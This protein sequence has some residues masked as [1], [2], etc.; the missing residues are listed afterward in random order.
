MSLR[1][2]TSSYFG[3]GSL[4]NYRWIISSRGYA[5]VVK[6]SPS[7]GTADVVYGMLYTLQPEDEARLD[8]AEGVPYSYVKFLLPIELVGSK[9]GEDGGRGPQKDAGAEREIVPA[10]VYVDLKRTEDGVCREEYVARMNRGI[11]DAVTK[12]MSGE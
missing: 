1:C 4:P 7:E 6:S 3:F 9:E 2:P 8:L 10:L 11:R 12:G 5:N